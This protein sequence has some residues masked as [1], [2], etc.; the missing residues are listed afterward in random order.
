M[1]KPHYGPIYDDIGCRHANFKY[2]L[3]HCKS[4]KDRKVCNSLVKKLML[5]NSKKFWSEI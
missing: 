4:D 1:V 2:A 3:R 5:K